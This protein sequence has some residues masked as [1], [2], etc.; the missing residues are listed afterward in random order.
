MSQR[1]RA[2]Q[3]Y[4]WRKYRGAC[5][6]SVPYRADCSSLLFAAQLSRCAVPGFM[7]VK[8]GAGLLLLTAA[9]PALNEVGYHL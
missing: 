2:C 8:S 3:G 1:P 9:V 4:E 6:K 5:F 7:P